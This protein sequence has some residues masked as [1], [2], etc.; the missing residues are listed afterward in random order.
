[1]NS[2]LSLTA[3]T[4]ILLTNSASSQNHLSSTESH[5]WQFG[6]GAKATLEI[7]R[8]G[9]QARLGLNTGVARPIVSNIIYPAAHLEWEL[10]Q[11]G[12]G[13]MSGSEQ[14]KSNFSGDLIGSVLVT[15]GGWYRGGQLD[16]QQ[17]VIRNQPLYYFTDMVQPVLQNPYRY[18]FS[19]G[20]NYVIPFDGQKHAQ[21]V[22]FID[23]HLENFQLGYYN[24]GGGFQ[25]IG[26]GDGNDRYYT[27]GGLISLT[28]PTCN[29]INTFI[30]S[31]HKFSGFSPNAFELSS[32]LSLSFV[33]YTNPDQQYYNKSYWNFSISNV[34]TGLYA[35][36]RINNTYNRLDFQNTIHYSFS[37][38]Y[39]Q[40]PYPRYW[41]YG[42]SYFNTLTN[43]AP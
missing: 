6:I 23:F 9:V 33:N 26:I 28:L 13:T 29:Y 40:I 27:G 2:K 3:V 5:R 24:D 34:K 30:A 38:S 10:Y 25:G 11:G 42:I 15:S 37:Y 39:H 41:S 35:F 17:M 32:A 8:S 19:I 22:G 20:T 21:Q 12:L 4:F 18:S 7:Q 36:A 43:I 31:Y 16:P 1:M 14:N